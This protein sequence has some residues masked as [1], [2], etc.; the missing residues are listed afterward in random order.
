VAGRIHQ[1]DIDEV[2]QR[3]RIDD[4][5]AG[6][7]S[8]RRAGA[9]T[10]KGLCP[11]HDEKT[12]SFQVTPSRG[13]FYCF[14]CGA[15]GDVFTFLR[16]INNLSFTEATE[17]LAQKYGVHL[18]YEATDPSQPP[19]LPAGRR[20]R[21]LEANSI[22]A[23][24]FAQALRSP[25]AAP[26]RRFL[27]DRGFDQA[28]AERFGVG[29]APSDGRALAGHLRGRG[30]GEEELLEAGLVRRGG[31]DYFQRRL[32]WPIR[33]AGQSV[34]GFGARRLF[35]DDRLPA[36]Y[37][38]TPE[39]PLYK[40]SHVLYGL[41][42]ARAAIGKSARAVVVEGYTDVMACHL[43]GIDTAVATCG[44]S[45]GDDHA[46]LIQR[47]LGGDAFHGEVVFTF[48]G[49]AAGQKAALRVF[50]GDSHFAA[51][52]YVAVEPNG[53]DPCDVRL[54]LGDAA[55]RE[56]VARREPLYRF[57]MRHV[58]RRHDLDRVEG[59]IE[60]V[61]EA[62]P[63]LRSARDQAKRDGYLREVASL[64]G[65]DVEEVRRIV[66]QANR[67]PG[68]PWGEPGRGRAVTGSDAPGEGV[69]GARGPGQAEAGA[70]ETPPRPPVPLPAP[71][72]RAL[73]VERDTVKL[74]L[75]RPDLFSVEPPWNDVMATDFSH[76]AYAAVFRAIAATGQPGAGDWTRRVLA[77]L[78]EDGLREWSVQLALE[79]VAVEPAPRH[80]G[81]YVAKLKVLE[82]SRRLADLRST[83]QR[84]NP[85]TEPA[86]HQE[87]F[88]TLLTLELRRKQLLEASVS[89]WV[90]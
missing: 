65:L 12:P 15:G 87:L 24:F 28:A 81:E 44:T 26:G 21:L 74:M 58:I 39:T 78:P 48:D 41:D 90:G 76:P 49:D 64:V 2:R 37:I 46:R 70:P 13:L 4:V 72:D 73:V 82:L 52:T 59:R 89:D 14:G 3:A 29:F 50:S 60:A 7:V 32:V 54:Q 80:A 35:D 19:Q 9:G 45:F 17:F 61:R 10:L 57:V 69:A 22:A 51:Q 66:R 71:D 34:L 79:P 75:Q 5:V 86:R 20:V 62:A 16:Q 77:S 11:F 67:Q 56:L 85:V 88:Q 83:M 1:E 27:V 36:K 30:F 40:K 43:A 53:L 25:E 6:W 47:L 84:T 33:D 38:N 68:R 8:L 55:L 18:R 42:L 23:E 63:L 31:W